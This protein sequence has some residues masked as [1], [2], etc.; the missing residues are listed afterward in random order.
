[1][2]KA[3]IALAAASALAMGTIAVPQKAEAHAWWVIPSIVLGAAVVGGAAIASSRAHAYYAPAPYAPR[4]SVHVA[5]TRGCYMQAQ[6]AL[7]GGYRHIEV[8]R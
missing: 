7:F 8:C 3:I 5:P 1:M 4:G 6:P 2:K